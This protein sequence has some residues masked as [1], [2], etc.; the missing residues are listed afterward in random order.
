MNKRCVWAKLW[1]IRKIV[2]KTPSMTG[3]FKIQLINMGT[4]AA[5]CK[6]NWIYWV[7]VRQL[8]TFSFALISVQ[9]KL[10]CLHDYHLRLLHNVVPPPSGVDIANTIKYFSQ[11]FLSIILS[12]QTLFTHLIQNLKLFLSSCS[13]F[14]R[15]TKFSTSNDKRPFTGPYTH[16]GLP[17]SGVWK[18]IQC[19][20]Y[21]FRC[22]TK[23]TIRSK[24]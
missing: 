22:C 24:W 23:H 1:I 21:A 2:R 4:R 6:P 9:A 10:R 8:Y 16:V 15:C 5:A 19:P 12:L 7:K 13:R 17:K 18:S 14:E 20:R 3:S 11:T